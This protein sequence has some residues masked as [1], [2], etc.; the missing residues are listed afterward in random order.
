MSTSSS[1]I[2]AR[3][4]SRAIILLAHGS[5]QPAAAGGLA[6]TVQALLGR[7]DVPVH[8]AFLENGEPSLMDAASVLLDGGVTDLTILPLLLFDGRH[9][10]EDIPALIETLR[11]RYPS[12]RINLGRPL[13]YSP[14]LV[15]V[16]L[17]RLDSCRS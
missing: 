10:L 5:R 15:D 12:V 17:E 6:E 8:G 7:Q 14:L 4:A 2:E 16:L 11:L 9:S 1:E 13:G 3:G